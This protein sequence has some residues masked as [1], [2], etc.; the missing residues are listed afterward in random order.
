[1]KKSLFSLLVFFAIAVTAQSR[2]GY[3]S[4]KEVVKALPEYSIVE[5]HLDELQA[6]YEAEIERADREF[7]QKYAD[8]IEEQDKFPDNIRIKRH[9]E[10]QELMEKAIA[11]KSEVSSAMR[12]AR[13][14]M[15]N[16]L[17]DKVDEAV[18]KVCIDGNFDYILDS[19][20]RVYLTINPRS[21]H[22]VTKQVKN[23]LGVDIE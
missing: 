4:Y 8:F 19:D 5:A 13:Q 1:M 21:G 16:P 6:M 10:L 18:K 23:S 20:K 17:Y 11:F 22:D 3:I 2:F 14:E 7:N 12:K 9:K 15:L